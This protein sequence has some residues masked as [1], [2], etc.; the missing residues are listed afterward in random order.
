MI[1][2]IIRKKAKKS[3]TSTQ[4]CQLY[5][6]SKESKQGKVTYTWAMSQHQEVGRLVSLLAPCL[7]IR[8]VG[9]PDDTMM[10]TCLIRVARHLNQDLSAGGRYVCFEKAFTQG[11]K[12]S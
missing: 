1:I 10:V 9:A 8:D 2:T 12:R 5:E 4:Y 11:L 7:L 3:F 6:Y